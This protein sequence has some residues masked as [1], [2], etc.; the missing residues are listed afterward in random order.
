MSSVCVCHP[1]S[2]ELRALLFH[3]GEGLHADM[4]VPLLSQLHSEWVQMETRFVVLLSLQTVVY[5]SIKRA[6][7]SLMLP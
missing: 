3:E 4:H 1:D 2:T 6:I 7:E 5:F